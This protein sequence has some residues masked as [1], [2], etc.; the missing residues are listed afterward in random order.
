[1][2]PGSC[3]GI[4]VFCFSNVQFLLKN[5]YY[6]YNYWEFI[7]IALSWNLHGNYL[8]FINF[9][10]LHSSSFLY[11]LL[12]RKIMATK[13]KFICCVCNSYILYH[14]YLWIWNIK[15]NIL[16]YL[17]IQDKFV[18]ICLKSMDSSRLAFILILMF[19]FE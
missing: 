17:Y 12:W 19:S 5:Y 9:F 16:S 15:E 11:L 8:L 1:M 3:Q 10:Y 6:H 4:M 13:I 18:I 7:L 14:F 2:W